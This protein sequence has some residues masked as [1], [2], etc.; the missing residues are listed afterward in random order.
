MKPEDKVHPDRDKWF[1]MQQ[2]SA[3]QKFK[4]HT[5]YLED[6]EMRD[7]ILRFID[8]THDPFATEIRYHRSCW[9]KYIAAVYAGDQEQPDVHLQNVRPSEAAI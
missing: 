1:L 6:M 3:W 4:T 9:N 2:Q 5:V 7:R 8:C